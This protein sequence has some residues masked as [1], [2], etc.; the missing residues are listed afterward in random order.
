MAKGKI[1]DLYANKL[2]GEVTES[3]ANTLTFNEINTNVSIFDK[4][5]WILNRLEWYI[6]SATSQLIQAGVDFIEFALTASNNIGDLLLSNASVIDTVLFNVLAP[7]DLTGAVIMDNPLIR[8]FSTLPGGGL[9][10][11]PRPLYVAIK[12]TSLATP[13]TVQVRGY[14]TQLPLGAEDYLELI[15]FYRIVS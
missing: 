10:I 12:G 8:D 15:D 11:A 1:R 9:I 5:G 14:F 6:P 3:A 7:V 2:F 4:V 13:A